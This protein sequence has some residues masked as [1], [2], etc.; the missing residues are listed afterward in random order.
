[1]FTV[2]PTFFSSAGDHPAGDGLT[3]LQCT[4]AGAS[5]ADVSS[6]LIGSGTNDEMNLFE[7]YAQ[8]LFDSNAN[9]KS[10]LYS[11]VGLSLITDDAPL[12]YELFFKASGNTQVPGDQIKFAQFTLHQYGLD[13]VIRGIPNDTDIIIKQTGFTDVYVTAGLT[14][15]LVNHLT[16]VNRSTGVMDVYL[17]GVRVITARDNATTREPLGTFQFGGVGRGDTTLTYYGGRVRRAE[18]YSGA[19]FIPPSSTAAWGAP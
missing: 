2:G 4:F 18:M 14:Y 13:F 3:R 5:S 11:D 1:M 9:P 7:G 16:L 15:G 19:S 6:Y 12:T 17:N 8:T 10:L